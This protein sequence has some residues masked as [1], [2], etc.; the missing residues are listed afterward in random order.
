MGGSE[1]RHCVEIIDCRTNRIVMTFENVYIDL[2]FFAGTGSYDF[3]IQFMEDQTDHTVRVDEYV[4]TQSGV[5][6][7]NF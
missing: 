2:D 4:I 6:K 7:T 1:N 5:H 3:K